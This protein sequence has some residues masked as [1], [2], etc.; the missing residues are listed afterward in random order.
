MFV[1]A[2]SRLRRGETRIAD[3][4]LKPALWSPASSF[5][6]GLLNHEA[7]RPLV[8]DENPSI[9]RTPLVIAMWEQLADALRLPASASSATRSCASSRT[10]GLGRRRQAAVR[11]V[12]VRPHQPRL[13]DVRPV[14]GRR[15]LL[16]RRGQAGG[17]HGGR[18]REGAAP[19][20]ASSSARSCTTATRRCS[21]PRRCASTGSVTRRRS[22]WRRS[23]LLEFNR[24]A[25]APATG[26][27]RSTRRRA[28]SSPTT[29]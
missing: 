22:R 27:S 2:H 8:P 9:V 12:Q 14:G 24:D 4:T 26:S 3:G 18:R 5:W 7:D 16:R 25:R 15:V 6:G 29:R 13:L 1:D 21:S 10:D 19:R 28:R 17:P 23:T 20:S 11:R